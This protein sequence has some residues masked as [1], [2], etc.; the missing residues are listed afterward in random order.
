MEASGT[1][2]VAPPSIGPSRPLGCIRAGMVP[3]NLDPGG[4]VFPI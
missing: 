4:L 2:E 3:G 1:H